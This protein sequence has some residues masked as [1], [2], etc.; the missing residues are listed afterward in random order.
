MIQ[1]SGVLNRGHRR[2]DVQMIV[3]ATKVLSREISLDK[4]QQNN[5]AD[6]ENTIIFQ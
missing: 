2:T 3:E 1:C 4:K 5:K 6:G